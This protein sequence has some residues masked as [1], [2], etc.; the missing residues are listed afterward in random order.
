MWHL[1]N[2]GVN[3]CQGDPY[4]SDI[5]IE[6]H[7]RYPPPYLSPSRVSAA[8]RWYSFSKSFADEE[9]ILEDMTPVSAMTYWWLWSV[10]PGW[11][12]KWRKINK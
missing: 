12:G 10:H 4:L 3:G 6:L 2:A 9:A 8:M 1:H 5:Q 7:T 11:C